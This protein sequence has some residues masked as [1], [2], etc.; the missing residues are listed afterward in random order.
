MCRK[1]TIRWAALALA[2]VSAGY[3]QVR[4]DWRRVGSSAVELS[5]ASPATG[6][7]AQ[8]WFS[9]EGSRLFARTASGQTFV[10]SDYETW[11]GAV[12]AA[13]PAEP[14]QGAARLP[15]PGAQLV[16]DARV[17]GRIYA[18]GQQLSRSEDGGRSW[19]S[20]TQYRSSSVV[21]AGERSL[22]VSPLDPQQLVIGNDYG[23]WRSMDG[24]LTWAGLNQS[25]PNLPVRRI[26]ATPRGAAGT[27]IEV[28]GMGTFELPPGSS[29]WFPASVSQQNAEAARLAQYSATIGAPITAAGAAGSTVYAGSR[30]GRIWVSLDSGNSFRL[31]RAETAGQ[32]ERIYVDP[33]E[34]RVALAALAGA[35]AHILR[36]TSSGSLWDDL[37]GNLP[38]VPAHGVTA[39]RTAGAVYVATDSGVFLGRTDLENATVPQ[40]EWVKL[41]DALPA[42][43]A[44]D[45]R[46]DPADV[47]LYIALDGYGVYATAAPHRLWNLRVVSAA[48][49]STRPAAPGSLLS[50]VGGRVNAAR[51]GDLTYPV[52]AAGETESQIQ[53]P[54][55]AV[56]PSV[57]LSLQTNAGQVTLGLPVLPAAPAIF[58]GHDGAPMLYDAD[59]GLLL[60]ARNAA[61]SGGRIQILATGLGKVQPDW[62]TNLAA[63]LQNPPVVAATVR[64]YLDGAPLQVTQATLAPGNIGFYLIEAQLP[65]IA[66]LGTSELYISEGGQESNRV[67]VVVEP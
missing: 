31:S 17:P 19:M 30:D 47:Q 32:V 63:P 18:L 24:G 58:V 22:A 43:P 11:S 28:A 50:I 41:T 38:N 36:T 35:G 55:E 48:D 62:P 45:V 3:G 40:V 20:L 42:A 25:L 26:V 44:A 4:P 51:G 49:Y 60:D 34:P 67:Q 56:G 15:E 23:V 7:V 6:A 29:T 5:L 9:S 65:A 1:A 59:S 2:A 54:F 64:A 52:L 61:H 57:A 33:Q 8:V 66:N 39:E 27:Q 16:A 10:T 53:V 13:P 46:L 21:G 37:T 14:L 12:A